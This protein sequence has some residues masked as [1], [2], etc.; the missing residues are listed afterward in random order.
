MTLY[1]V[2]WN[3]AVGYYRRRNHHRSL[4]YAIQLEKEWN[5]IKPKEE[6]DDEE[7]GEEE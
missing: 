4:D 2:S 6:E 5:L 1:T 7:E 3:L